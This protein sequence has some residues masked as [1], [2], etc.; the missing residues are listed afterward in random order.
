MLLLVAAIT[1]N[2]VFDDFSYS[3]HLVTL[4]L[5]VIFFGGPF[6]EFNKVSEIS[7]SAAPITSATI[8]RYFTTLAGHIVVSMHALNDIIAQLTLAFIYNNYFTC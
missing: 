2:K 6:T 8:Y 4:K 3:C 7:C 5:C 1:G